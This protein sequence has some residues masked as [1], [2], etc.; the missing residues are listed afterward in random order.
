MNQVLDLDIFTYVVSCTTFLVQSSSLDLD[1]CTVG[2]CKT[3]FGKPCKMFAT[4]A[5]LMY[6]QGAK[7]AILKNFFPI[8][9]FSFLSQYRLIRKSDQHIGHRATSTCCHP[10]L[11]VTQSKQLLT[12][13]PSTHGALSA[14]IL[15]RVSCHQVQYP[16]LVGSLGKKNWFF[17]C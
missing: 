4:T 13:K 1:G 6:P 2:F 17:S 5:E 15:S 7:K 10:T 9:F 11:T 14:F 3:I 8:L 12:Y 16:A